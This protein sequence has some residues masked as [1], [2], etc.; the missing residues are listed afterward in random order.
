VVRRIGLVSSVVPLA[1]FMAAVLRPT[2]HPAIVSAQS[3]AAKVDFGRDVQPLLQQ[4]CVGCHGPAQQMNGLRLDRRR[5][6]MRGGSAGGVVIRPGNGE[7][8]ALYLKVAGTAFGA[9]MPPTGALKPEQ[10]AVIK[11]WIDEGAEWPDSLAGDVAPAPADPAAERLIDAVRSRAI[12]VLAR[13]LEGDAAGVNKRGDGGSTPLMWAALEGDIEP[14]R[15][16]LGAG[17]DPNLKND[18]GAT[19]L[20]WAIPDLPIVSLLLERGADVNVKTTDGRTPLLRAAGIYGTSALVKRLLDAGA[21]PK[22][23]GVSLFGQNTALTEAAYAADADTIR[24]LLA[25]GIDAGVDGPAPLYFALRAGCARCEEALIEAT[26]LPLL[27]MAAMFHSPPGGNARQLKR[28]IDRGIGVNPRDPEGRSLLM[29]A[30]SAEGLPLDVVEAL[31]ATGGDPR[32]ES[33]DGRAVTDFARMQGQTP[34][35]Q[36]LMKAGARSAVEPPPAPPAV[37]AASARDAVQRSLPLLQRTDETFWKKAGCVSCHNNTLT[38]ETVAAARQLSMKVDE[39]IATRQRRTIAGFLESWR[40][41]ALQGIG[42][43]GDAD[44]V[45]YILLGLAAEAHPADRATDAMARFLL[46]RQGPDGQWFLLAHRPPIESSVI[47]VTAASM[48]ALQ[49]YGGRHG[50]ASTRA[51]RRAA[52]WIANATVESNEDRVFRVMGLTWAARGTDDVARIATGDAIAAAV[53]DLKAAQRPDGGW[54]QT[55]SLA[56]DAYATGQALVALA[57]SGLVPRDDDSRRRGTEFLLNTQLA[58]GSWFVRTRALPIQPYFEA[59]FPHGRNQF[60][61]AA[62]TNWAA[63]ALLLD[64]K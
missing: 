46:D 39:E 44:T 59:D 55:S 48:R 45:S 52:E 62:A 6:A 36:A 11:Q 3:P 34:V 16:L 61:S 15:M 41:R 27:A 63:R 58:D 30:A 2:V 17:A 54:A 38:A 4:H 47:E 64:L 56:S 49:V 40:E 25:R 14:V 33:K 23:K 13:A 57:T 53:R 8:S 32:A 19:A 51:I 24:L 21:D 43:P 1:F 9:Q 10:I 29:L 12:G 35:L 28:L 22:A 5:D 50:G 26:P 20:M 7:I 31:I 37:R 60:I 18:A 42:I